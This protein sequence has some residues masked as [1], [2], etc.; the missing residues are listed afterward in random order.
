MAQMTRQARLQAT[1]AGEPVDRVAVALW[2]H[3]PGDDQRPADL[4]DATLMWQ[5]TWDWDFIKVSPAS[6]FCLVDWGAQDRWVGGDEGNREYTRRVIAEPPGWGELA[7]LDPARGALARQI[8][9]LRRIQEGV[10]EDVPYIQTV[11]S[12]LAQA[13]NLAGQ[14]RLIVHLRQAPELVHAGL[15][16]I[17]ETT[18]R[19]IEAA[20]ATRI[21]GIYYAVQLANLGLLS[22]DEYRQFGEPYDRRILAAVQDLWF[23]MAHLHG[24]DGMFDLI[25]RYPVHALNWH[26]RE[27]GPALGEGQKRFN[28][29]VCGGLE[30]WDHLLRG[31]PDQIRAVV[32]DAVEQ[33]AGRRLVVSSGC[34]APVNAP[35]SN[36]R[37]VR[38]AVEIG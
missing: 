6:S 13:K 34:V 28:G 22:E 36:L 10:G 5:R 21:A 15:E 35:F 20:K 3:F 32:A 4:A 18:L 9:C 8:E 33:T 14:E 19:F 11:F 37:A 23:N 30:H 16:I 31:E 24:R 1:V 38:T 12:P 7:P 17:T 2:R 25:A 29:A 27:S 26:D